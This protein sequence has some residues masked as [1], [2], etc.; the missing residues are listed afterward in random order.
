MPTDE[1]LYARACAGDRSALAELIERYHSPIRRFLCRMTNDEQMAEDLVHDTFIRVLSHEG[2]APRTFRPWLF[3]V[4]RNLA[5]DAFRSASYRREISAG[6]D[7]GAWLA[8]SSQG[9][10]RMAERRSRRAEVGEILQRLQ[11][12][13]REVLVL[14]F[15][16]DLSLREI[17]AVVDSPVGTVKSR[18]YYAL[19][20]AKAELE[21]REVLAHER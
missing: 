12:H 6:P 11:P 9:A 1:S 17:A 21:R 18:L 13:H 20:Q 3:T 19:R 4:A 5:Y 15:Y 16:H 7:D 14:R 2:D 8:A 10:E